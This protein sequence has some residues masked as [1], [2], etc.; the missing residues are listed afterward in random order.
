ME[1]VLEYIYKWCSTSVL[2]SFEDS[3]GLN[4]TVLRRPDP[5]TLILTPSFYIIT[6]PS[7]HLYSPHPQKKLLLSIH[8]WEFSKIQ[9]QAEK[10]PVA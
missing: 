4:W 6:F 5:T 7:G 1:W 9:V 10:L 8:S 3:L 2:V